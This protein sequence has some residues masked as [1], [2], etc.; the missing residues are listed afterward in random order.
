MAVS[1]EEHE[2]L[3]AQLEAQKAE[4]IELRKQLATAL[5][6]I[7][8]LTEHVKKNSTNSNLPP[9]SD[10]PGA[11]SRGVRKPKKQK[12]GRKRGG[13]KGR[14]GAHRELLAPEGVH[15]VVDVFPHA[16]E[17]CSRGLPQAPDIDAR[18]Y[19]R[20]ELLLSG[21]QVTEWRRHAVTCGCGYTTRAPFDR[22]Q[23]PASPFGP[24]LVSIVAALT[25]VYHLSRR[26]T[27][28]FLH[29]VFCIDVSLGAVSRME[30]RVSEALT[31]ATDEAHQDVV[32]AMVKHADA[33]SWLIAGLTMSLWTMSTKRT[34]V[35]RIFKDGARATIEVMFAGEDGKQTG[36]LVSD[37]ASVFGFWPMAL[38]QICWAHL[39]RLFV[40]FSQRDGPVGTFGRELLAGVRRRHLVARRT[41]AL[42][43]ACA[44]SLRGVARSHRR[45]RPPWLFGFV[46]KPS[47]P[48]ARLLELRGH[49]GRRPHQ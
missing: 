1:Q 26:N 47:C 16:C 23:I 11:A 21:P 33:T 28:K 46:R 38:R 29:E 42:D 43:G 8:R 3:V 24:R 7:V 5:D 25:G 45:G 14:R 20:I 6:A 2:E 49:R 10:G 12:S 34:T 30:A 4:N 27:Q 40:S 44:A 31:S 13:Q 39:L 36:I 18:R 32:S 37:R 41:R 9:S 17:G 48:R 22:A 19:Q 35:F 15:E